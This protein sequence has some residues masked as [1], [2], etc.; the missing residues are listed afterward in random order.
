M[1]LAGDLRPIVGSTA[2]D[3]FSQSGVF[4]AARCCRRTGSSHVGGAIRQSEMD[5]N[6][7]SVGRTMNKMGYMCILRLATHLYRREQNR[8]DGPRVS[9]ESRQLITTFWQW[10][11]FP[12]D[13]NSHN[14]R[15]SSKP[16]VS[17]VVTHDR[18]FE[19]ESFEI[20]T[21]MVMQTRL[22][23]TRLLPLGSRRRSQSKF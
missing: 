7:T 6:G 12:D 14:E 15:C 10:F 22:H 3:S 20:A 9:Q 17:R 4:L 21:K 2:F 8:F 13:I 1:P 11:Y 18:D 5:S 23:I 16:N 19:T